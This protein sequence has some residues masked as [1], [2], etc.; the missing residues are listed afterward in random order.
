VA[1]L[2]SGALVLL[3]PTLYEGFGFPVLEAMCCG[4]P[5]ITS[6]TSSLPE[7]AGEAALLVD[8]RDVDAIA[9]ALQRVVT[10]PTLRAELVARGREHATRF[11]WQRAAEQAL[12]TLE[13]AAAR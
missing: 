10:E 6:N 11:T 2:Y 9:D 7:V 8:P 1:A 12:H 5:V 3:F 13:A 4:T